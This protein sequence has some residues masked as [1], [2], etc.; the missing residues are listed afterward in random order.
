MNN[1]NLDKIQ[2]F[3]KEI[4]E[5]ASVAQK[6]K[7]VA[8]SWNFGEGEHQYEATVEYPSGSMTFRSDQAPFMGGNG[9]AP[10]PIQYCLY[11]VSSCYA[12]TLV[13]IAAMEG[14]ELKGLRVTAKNRIN[15]QKALGLS[16]QPIIQ[17]VTLTVEAEPVE[18]TSFDEIERVA[19]MAEEKCPGMEC[20]RREIPYTVEVKSP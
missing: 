2:N 1:V 20:M 7:V 8:G 19:R 4:E 17:G 18:G 13:T 9:Q 11:G 15:L 6:E 3:V 16:D 14:I 5:D 10:D 12:G